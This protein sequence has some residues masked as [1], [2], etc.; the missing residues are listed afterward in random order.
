MYS[1]TGNAV[2]PVY[3]FVAGEYRWQ[4]TSTL[5]LIS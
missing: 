5:R 2:T 3:F 1:G 4:F